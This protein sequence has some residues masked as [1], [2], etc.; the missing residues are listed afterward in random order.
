MKS[1][2]E[3]SQFETFFAARFELVTPVAGSPQ[4]HAGAPQHAAPLPPKATPRPTLASLA[5]MAEARAWGEA[6]ARDIALC[7]L[8]QLSWSELDR[9]CLLYGPPGTGKTTFATVFAETCGL[10]LISTSFAQ[11]QGAPGGHLGTTI[12]AIKKVFAEAKQKAPCVLAIGEIDSI[13]Q[14]GRSENMVGYM[15]QVTNAVLT[16]FDALPS[17]AGVIV[18]GSCNHPDLL[19]PALVRAG[20]MDRMIEV[21]LPTVRE[22]EGIVRYHLS[23]QD[24]VALGADRYDGP[25]PDI[26]RLCAGLSGADVAKAV[27]NARQH[28]RHHRVPLSLASFEEVL[29]PPAKRPDPDTRYRI[30][31]HEAGHALA[32]LRLNISD[33]ITASIIA[34]NGTAGGVAFRPRVPH[35]TRAT[36]EH[37]LIVALA[38][39]VAEEIILGA[40]S[41]LSG[42]DSKDS[43]L[44]VA[45]KLA[46]DAVIKLGFSQNGGLR[47]HGGD[48][49]SVLL[50]AGPLAEEIKQ[51]L[52]A[53]H[54]QATEM[55]NKDRPF[56][57]L[58][59]EA[60]IMRRVLSHADIRMLDGGEE[61]PKPHRAPA[62][63]S[64]PQAQPQH[65]APFAWP[66]PPQ[67]IQPP[68]PPD[69]RSLFVPTPRSQRAAQD[70]RHS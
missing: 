45:T 7:R 30:A 26:A 59:A 38:G 24:R 27:R 1:P 58:L 57:E 42:G 54:S 64:I 13:P 29:D 41:S 52:D 6:V 68:P 47:W 65:G 18:V 2:Y 16:E 31:V 12:E 40:P 61:P 14:R 32:A 60:L 17:V 70:G 43:D 37:M 19:D 69:L 50:A 11:W 48:G 55:L 36:L 15:N 25:L 62:A 56:L 9:G 66:V 35:Q 4:L 21:R 28:A 44:A 53:A 39:R 46:I 63:P 51:M 23:E 33:E 10:P 20:R 5:G 8:G 3:A 67:R 34:R 22:L 49:Q